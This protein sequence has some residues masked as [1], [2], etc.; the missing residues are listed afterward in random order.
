VYTLFFIHSSSFQA[1][2]LL[3]TGHK[4]KSEH[5]FHTHYHYYLELSGALHDLIPLKTKIAK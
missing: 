1:T 5:D 4:S 3:P 2:P